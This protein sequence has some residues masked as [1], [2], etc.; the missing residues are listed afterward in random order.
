[1]LCSD[2]RLY[3]PRLAE[4]ALK[5]WAKLNRRS[6]G[7]GDPTAWP[8]LRLEVFRRDDFTCQYCDKR[9]GKLHCDHVVPVSRGGLDHPSNLVTACE[10]CNLSKR[11]KP[12]EVFLADRPDR[13]QAVLARLAPGGAA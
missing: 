5:A 12:L 3:H 1:M 10:P 6:R 11:A 9:G 2:G 7:G 4:H 8:L 13:I